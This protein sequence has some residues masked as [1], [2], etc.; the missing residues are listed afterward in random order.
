[1]KEENQTEQHAKFLKWLCRHFVS[2]TADLKIRNKDGRTSLRFVSYAG[3]VV[4]LHEHWFLVTA[5]HILKWLAEGVKDKRFSFARCE[6]V[7]Y[8]GQGAKSEFGVPFNILEKAQFSLDDDRLGAD[9]GFVQVIPHYQRLLQQN[10]V[11]AIP[12]ENW[13]THQQLDFEFFGILGLPEELLDHRRRVAAD[14]ATIAGGM[15]PALMA[16]NSSDALPVDKPKPVS[17]WLAI[18]LRDKHEIK[19]MKGMSG[20][21]IFGFFRGPENQLLY[22]IAGVQSWWDRN[23]RIAFGTRLPPFVDLIERKMRQLQG[24][25]PRQPTRG[26]RRPKKQK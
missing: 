24:S 4:S 17:P 18:E 3:F 7:D 25:E 21:P 13:R 11:V 9:I 16:G 14:G 15:R 19:S 6:L 2:I 5:G 22:T 1:M 10:G 23:R 26:K 12:Q 20:G 8:Y